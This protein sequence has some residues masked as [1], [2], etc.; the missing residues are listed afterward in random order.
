MFAILEEVLCNMNELKPFMR[1]AVEKKKSCAAVL[2][3]I[4]Y[5]Y[6]DNFVGV[7]P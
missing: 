6:S 3:M 7:F 4:F 2:T 5:D 1:V